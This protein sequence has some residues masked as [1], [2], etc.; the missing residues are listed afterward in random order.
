[1]HQENKI[2]IPKETG[3]KTYWTL[4]LFTNPLQIFVRWTP[5]KKKFRC[6]NFTLRLH[7]HVSKKN[8]QMSPPS[9]PSENVS[10]IIGTDP[11]NENLA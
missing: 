7:L 8:V 10:A 11:A 2:K 9:V 3:N 5:G 4:L 6:E 1:M